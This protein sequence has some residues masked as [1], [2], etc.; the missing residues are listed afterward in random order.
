MLTIWQILFICQNCYLLKNILHIAF[1]DYI[2]WN[3]KD[4]NKLENKNIIVTLFF[5]IQYFF[6]FSLFF[7]SLEKFAEESN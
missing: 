3:F 4:F 2:S 5:S 6:I 1:D 7:I